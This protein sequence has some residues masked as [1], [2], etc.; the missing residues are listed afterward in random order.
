MEG[1][2]VMV[3]TGPMNI[4]LLATPVALL[5]YWLDWNAGVTFIFALLA[6]APFAERL[7]FVTEQ[8]ALHTNDTIGG[9]LNAT[10]G[11]ATELIVSIAALFKGLY[12]LVQLSLLGSILSNLLL[13]LGCAFFFGGLKFKEQYFGTI[14]SQINSTLLLCAAMGVLFPT[15][16]TYANEEGLKEEL[17]FS[18]ATAMVLFVLYF[19]FLYFQL[20][21]HKN[22]YDSVTEGKEPSNLLAGAREGS[23]ADLSNSFINSAEMISAAAS[24]ATTTES[25]D[26]PVA[27]AD[28]DEEEDVLGVKYAVVW[29]TIITVFISVLSDAL[30]SSIETAASGT[31]ISS[32]FLS[33]IV[34]PIVGN[35]AEHASAVLVAMKNKLDLSLGVAV[36]SSTQIALMVLPFTVLVGWCA[37]RPMSLNFYAYEA[38]SLF[39]TVV[40]VTFAIKDG[41]SNWLL[42][43]ILVF[44]YIIIAI[45]FYSHDNED[46]G[47]DSRR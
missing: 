20:Y 15:V 21:T 26:S 34:I 30:V 38:A 9:L 40:V 4:L 24:T 13:V 6:I 3:M 19:M 23:S 18:R 39:A 29:L 5:S 31:G 35:A 14:S 44:A 27:A 1:A 25:D 8:L 41:K 45:G 22:V 16:L 12:R 36:G 43:A 46:L 47:E 2:K 11:N 32:V 10:F 33:A 17:G 7:G 28:D 37:D 42:G